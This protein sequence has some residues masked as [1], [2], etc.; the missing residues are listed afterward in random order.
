MWALGNCLSPL[1]DKAGP[2]L[3][4]A[5]FHPHT[6]N[7]RGQV[8]SKYVWKE[9]WQRGEAPR[10]PNAEPVRQAWAA[11]GSIGLPLLP[12]PRVSDCGDITKAVTDHAS[13]AGVAGFQQGSLHR[14]AGSTHSAWSRCVLSGTPLG[15]NAGD[16][17][18]QRLPRGRPWVRTL[19]TGHRLHRPAERSPPA[20][21]SMILQSSGGTAQCWSLTPPRGSLHV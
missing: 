21:F 1:A 4:H 11:G 17:P 15:Q 6:S 3:C 7:M 16:N 8:L 12:R 18:G 14:M 9:H 2:P 20:Q 13:G 10:M 19:G 5:A